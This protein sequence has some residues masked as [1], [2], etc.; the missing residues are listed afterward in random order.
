L[1]ELGDVACNFFFA[2]SLL[3]ARMN[4]RPMRNARQGRSEFVGCVGQQRFL[5][6]QQDLLRIQKV[7]NTF[8]RGIKPL[9]QIRHFILSE[10]CHANRQIAI[11]PSLYTLLQAPPAFV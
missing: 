1:I 4:S 6:S 2:S 3:S 11:T 10:L 8:C 7:L 5:R 9:G